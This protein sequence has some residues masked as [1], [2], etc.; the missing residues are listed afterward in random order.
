MSQESSKV[1]IRQWHTIH[2]LVKGQ[3]V[4]TAE[5]KT[6]L[7]THG[8]DVELR[9]IQR[10]L[11]MLEGIFPLECRRDSIPHSWR[12]KTLRDTRIKGLDITQACTL[13]LVED[14]LQG[15]IPAHIMQELQPLF[16]KAKVVT[17]NLPALHNALDNETYQ[18]SRLPQHGG[19]RGITP[20]SPVDG[21]IFE[22][23]MRIRAML[24]NP[25]KERQKRGKSALKQAIEHLNAQ[26]LNVWADK[27][28]TL[29]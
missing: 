7:A 15:V 17:G 22:M 19:L 9:T 25:E 21:V 8:F 10:D 18:H 12:W 28:K 5:I 29:T 23:T 14:Q 20:Q 27:L 24:H 6:H 11:V 16:E 3:Y 1:L 4:S 2:Y 26:G 13:R